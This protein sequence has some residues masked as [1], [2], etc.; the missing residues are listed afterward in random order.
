MPN[1]FFQKIVPFNEITWKIIVEWGR[2]QRA[3]WCMRIA[4]WITK[5]THTLRMYNTYCFSTAK[6]VTRTL[7]KFTIL[8]TVGVFLLHYV[9]D[10]FVW[11]QPLRII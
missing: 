7:L 2:P 10:I 8:R 1:N 4:C 5:A 11:Q 6:I 3:I 9:I